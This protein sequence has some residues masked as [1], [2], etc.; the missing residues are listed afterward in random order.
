MKLACLALLIPLAVVGFSGCGGEKSDSA[1]IE[2]VVKNHMDGIAEDDGEKACEGMTGPY[3]REI[4]SDD[5]SGDCPSRYE[6]FS[7]Q[8]GEEEKSAFAQ[9]EITD[10]ELD[11]DE[12]LA[13]YKLPQLSSDFDNTGVYNMEKFDGE[14]KIAS[15]NEIQTC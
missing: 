3:Q 10:I 14:W 2:E 4:F 15:N 12:A 6:Q 7:A 8:L 11:G 5:L 9:T 1:Q 13:C